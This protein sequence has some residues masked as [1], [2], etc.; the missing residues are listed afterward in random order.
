[1]ILPTTMPPI[2]PPEIEDDDVEF[3]ECA[4]EPVV[5]VAPLGTVWVEVT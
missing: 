4:D 2:A 5:G 1:M 3:C